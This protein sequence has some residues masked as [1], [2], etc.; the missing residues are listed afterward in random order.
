MGCNV[1]FLLRERGREHG[2]YK[3]LFADNTTLVVDSR[4][5]F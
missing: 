4:E 2:V 5:E 3:L 1:F